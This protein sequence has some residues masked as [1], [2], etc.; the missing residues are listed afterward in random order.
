MKGTTVQLE[1]KTQTGTDPFGAP[2]YS[3]TYEDVHDVLVGQ[4]STDDISAS[5]DLYGKRIEYMLG[6]PKGDTHNWIDAKVFIWGQ[7]FHTF[8]YPIT[9]EQENIPLRWGQNVRV[10]RFEMRGQTGS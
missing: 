5:T 8:G 3:V 6:I 9:G 2:I 1:V 4:P 7:P 10:E